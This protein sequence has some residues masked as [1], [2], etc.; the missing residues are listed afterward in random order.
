MKG[1][2]TDRGHVERIVIKNCALLKVKG[3]KPLAMFLKKWH[4]M[5]LCDCYSL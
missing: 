5:D 4:P 2:V 1:V 3:N